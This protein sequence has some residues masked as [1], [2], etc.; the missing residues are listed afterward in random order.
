M[1]SLI[2]IMRR[3]VLAVGGA[4]RV[5]EYLWWVLQR[6]KSQKLCPA[7]LQ[8]QLTAADDA[9]CQLNALVDAWGL[10]QARGWSLHSAF[11]LL[12]KQNAAQ[13]WSK[14]YALQLLFKGYALQAVSR[15]GRG[16]WIN[17]S[18]I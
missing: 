3:L 4:V 6:A 16:T 13:L 14:G 2:I 1:M 7:P 9:C 11:Q 8:C 17:L 10:L 12:S 5:L 18:K 15:V